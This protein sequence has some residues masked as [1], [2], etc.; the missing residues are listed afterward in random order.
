MGILLQ[1]QFVQSFDLPLK[2]KKKRIVDILGKHDW[3][4]GHS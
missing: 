3:Y 4:V 1:E 2:W